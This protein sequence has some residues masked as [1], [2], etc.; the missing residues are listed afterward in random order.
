MIYFAPFRHA[1][2]ALLRTLLECVTASMYFFML[3]KGMLVSH[4]LTFIISYSRK[5]KAALF[6]LI[7]LSSAVAFSFKCVKKELFNSQACLSKRNIVS[8]LEMSASGEVGNDCKITKTALKKMRGV[9]IS[10]E[11][12]PNSPLSSMD[13]EILSQGLRKFKVGSIW[14]TDLEAVTQFSKEQEAARGNFP[15]PCPIIYNGLSTGEAVK[16]GA[17]A[18]VLNAN[19]VETGDI[20]FSLGVDVIYSVNTVDEVRKVVDLDKGTGFLIPAELDND[21]IKDILTIIPK[22][23]LVIAFLSAMQSDSTEVLRGRE[24]SSIKSDESG[25]GIDALLFQKACVGDAEDLKYTNFVVESVTKKSSSQFK[26]TGLTGSTN[27][28]FGTSSD[29]P[30]NAKWRRA[31]P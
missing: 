1:P 11:Y 18:I 23:S 2:K 22:N 24:L 17:S 14:T 9:S 12:V 31:G 16:K 4:I 28:H 5:M 25:S 19:S 8:Y 13:F 20:E 15:G 27:G 7:Q 30:E 29:S 3:K 6:L 21:T 10:V 26:M